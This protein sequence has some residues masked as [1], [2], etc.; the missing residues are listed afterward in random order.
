MF[1]FPSRTDTQGL[2]L[3]EAMACSTPV[4]ALT[5]IGQN[6]I[7]ENNKNESLI[8]SKKVY[9]DELITFDYLEPKTYII[10]VIEDW[11][12]NGKWDTGNYKEKLQAETVHYFRKEIKVRSN[13]DVEENIVLPHEH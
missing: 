5:G 10:K 9:S 6:D 1:L 2:V 7:I 12:D 11:N 8:Q 13:W 4:I 3:L